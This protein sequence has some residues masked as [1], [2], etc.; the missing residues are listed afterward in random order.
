MLF[1]KKSVAAIAVICVAFLAVSA[2]C[3]GGK[4][5]QITIKFGGL[6]GVPNIA[7]NVAEDLGYYSE[8]GITFENYMLEPGTHASAAVAGDVDIA[9]MSPTALAMAVEAGNPVKAIGLTAYGEPWRNSGV[10]VA[11][12]GSGM[13]TVDDLKGKKIAVS[14]PG[15]VDHIYLLDILRDYGIEDDVEIVYA[16]WPFHVETLVSGGVDAVA[17]IPYYTAVMDLEGVDYTV[18]EKPAG[19]QAHK[20]VAVLVAS[21]S[22]IGNRG[23]DLERFLE[24]YYR[25]QAYLEEN[26]EAHA[27]YLVTYAGWKPEVADLLVEKEEIISLSVDGKFDRGAM[28]ELL[29]LMVNFGFLEEKMPL[30][31]MITEE[32]LPA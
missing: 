22:A 4:E 23:E 27:E 8:A 29:A 24:V 10:I 7:Q 17:M 12:E 2:G 25:T 9:L 6:Q 20:D 31:N 3:L 32:H 21:E 5:E 26:P 15:D 13:K 28:N 1:G 19:L 30:E 16:L 18:L 11:L 14:Y